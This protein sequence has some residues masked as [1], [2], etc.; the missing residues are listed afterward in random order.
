VYG[1]TFGAVCGASGCHA[2]GFVSGVCVPPSF[3]TADGWYAGYV[4]MGPPASC[5]ENVRWIAPGNLERSY[6]YQVIAKHQM[7]PQGRSLSDAQIRRVASWIC[8]GAP[9]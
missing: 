7:P 8:A 3:A 2:P 1:E 5:G 9:R 4:A 6:V